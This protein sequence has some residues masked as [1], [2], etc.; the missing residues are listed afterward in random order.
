MPANNPSVILCRSVSYPPPLAFAVGNSVPL[1]KPVVWLRL[2]GM[3]PPTIFEPTRIVICTNLV[4]IATTDFLLLLHLA[5]L[6]F[7]SCS[8]RT[9]PS[10]GTRILPMGS[11]RPRLLS[12]LPLRPAVGL[13][14]GLGRLWNRWVWQ[15]CL[16]VEGGFGRRDREARGWGAH[17]R[18]ELSQ[19]DLFFRFLLHLVHLPSGLF[20][21]QTE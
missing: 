11:P 17:P 8:N 18:G 5:P 15:G 16:L 10:S 3:P 13:R 9:H 7:G 20:P 6:L 4:W 1:E 19:N 12:G 14:V 2:S 21:K